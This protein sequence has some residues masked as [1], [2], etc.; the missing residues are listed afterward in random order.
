MAAQVESQESTV[1]IFNLHVD[2][3]KCKAIPTVFKYKIFQLDSIG[4]FTGIQVRNPGT[5]LCGIL[6]PG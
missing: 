5:R 2:T 4:E 3:R 6:C 1:C